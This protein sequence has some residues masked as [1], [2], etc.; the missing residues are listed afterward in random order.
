MEDTPDKIRRNVVVFSAAVVIGWFLNLKVMD[1]SKLFWSAD[2]SHVSVARLW[3]VVLAVLTYLLLRYRFDNSTNSQLVSLSEGLEEKR[4]N[5]VYQYLCRELQKI[6]RSGKISPIF[7]TS[8]LEEIEHQKEE[9]QNEHNQKYS[10]Q[11]Y[12]DSPWSEGTPI[13]DADT[14]WNGRIHISEKYF[15]D[16]DHP[17]RMDHSGLLHDFSVPLGG[18]AWVEIHTFT[19]VALYS[20]SAVDLIAPI[21]LAYAALLIT[22]NALA[23][24]WLK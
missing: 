22:A 12:A 6:N 17:R 13:E 8:L 16:G 5:Y 2:F 1:I 4:K 7:G 3:I 24:A 20:K 18:R 19:H 9:L 11:L 23:V 10:W 21:A 14:I 15:S